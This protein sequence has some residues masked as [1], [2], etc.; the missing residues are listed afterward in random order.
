MVTTEVSPWVSFWKWTMDGR[1]AIFTRINQYGNGRMMVFDAQ[2]W[3]MVLETTGCGSPTSLCGEYP[4]ALYPLGPRFLRADGWLTDLPARQTDLLGPWRTG[5]TLLVIFA[6][7]SPNAASLAFVTGIE[8]QTDFALYTAQG[9]GTQIQRMPLDSLPQSL[10]WTSDSRSVVVTTI[11][12]RYTLDVT[13]G[14]LQTTPLSTVT[15]SPPASATPTSTLSP[16][17]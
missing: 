6:D 8:L 2:T 5:P 13:T 14:Q 1:F 4:I 17:P 9:D 3:S 10:Q 11:L 12:S 16:T 7:W 15:P